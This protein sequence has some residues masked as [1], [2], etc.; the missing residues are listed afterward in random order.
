MNTLY[1]PEHQPPP[2][3][4]LQSTSNYA[5]GMIAT[6][7]LDQTH[8]TFTNLDVISGRVVLRLESSTNVTSVVLKLEGE[9]MTRLRPPPTSK[10]S[11]PKPV[12]EVHKVCIMVISFST[13]G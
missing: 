11:D 3:K 2:Q 1:P 7:I 12:R 9:S 5:G 8:N 4:A 13:S 6:I 10:D